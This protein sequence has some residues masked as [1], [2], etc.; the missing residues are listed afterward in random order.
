MK[1]QGHFERNLADPG[2]MSCIRSSKL[3]S[4]KTEANRFYRKEAKKK[5]VDTSKTRRC[6]ISDVQ[7]QTKA[8][9]VN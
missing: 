6:F 7:V 2:I 8:Y 3:K 1:L 4:W 9:K 5:D